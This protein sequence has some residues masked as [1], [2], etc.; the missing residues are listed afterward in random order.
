MSNRGRTYINIYMATMWGQWGKFSGVKGRGWGALGALSAGA[1][2]MLYYSKRICECLAHNGPR[3]PAQAPQ[4]DEVIQW[5]CSVTTM[6]KER[7]HG[8]TATLPG[9]GLTRRFP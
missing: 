9:G 6:R 3:G 4:S 5:S 8:S 2:R 1:R 7:E